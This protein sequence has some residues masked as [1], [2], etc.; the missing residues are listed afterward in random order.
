MSKTFFLEHHLKE[1]PT[2]LYGML[3]GL[4]HYPTGYTFAKMCEILIAACKK[5][6]IS[7]PTQELMS[8]FMWHPH[9]GKGGPQPH[10]EPHTI[11]SD[12]QRYE[13]GESDIHDLLKWFENRVLTS[14]FPLE[15][16][17]LG[18]H[19]YAL[20]KFIMI[21]SPFVMDDVVGKRVDLELPCRNE[22]ILMPT[23]SGT[24]VPHR[25]L[26]DVFINVPGEA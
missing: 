6:R 14:N 20:T 2:I 8:D 12:C 19:N 5:Q 1:K 4:T 16:L 22:S 21:D 10:I 9:I 15:P 26:L 13:L 3:L 25:G 23:A 24:F 7:A 11:E 17:I 18:S